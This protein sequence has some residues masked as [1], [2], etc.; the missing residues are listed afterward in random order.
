[1]RDNDQLPG[2]PVKPP[3]TL[4]ARLLSPLG[5]DGFLDEPDGLLVVD[6]DGRIAW[7][8]GASDR[9]GGVPPNAMDVRPMVVLPGLVDLHGHLP[10]L[11]ISGVGSNLGILD[12]LGDLMGPVERRFGRA[13]SARLSPR[14]FRQ[15]AAAGTTTACLYTSVDA[16]AT[17]AAFEAAERHGIRV[18][19]GQPLMDVGRYDADVP[20]RDVTDIRLSEAAQTCAKWNGRDGGRIMYTF[21]PRGALN[22]TARMMAESA[23]MARDAGAYWQTHLS[24]DLDEVKAVLGVHPDARDVLDTYER[25]GGL[26]PRCILAHCVYINERELARIAETGTVV[27]HCP[28]NVWLN[29]GVMRLAYYRERGLKVGLGADVGANMGGVSLWLAMQLGLISQSA[30]AILLGDREH[31]RRGRLRMLDWLRLATLDGARCLGIDDRIGSL[32]ISKDAD[33]ILVDPQMTSPVPGE[34]LADFDE[35]EAE[36]LMSRLISRP[37]PEMVRAAWVRGR[38]LPGPGGWEFDE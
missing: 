6:G 34:R 18:N 4:R 8:G 30:R 23:V 11:P 16:G 5:S 12:W 27:A 21:T 17:D 14:Y 19:M 26:G 20:D 35:D 1:M 25:A 3:F 2:F 29:F 10:Q 22:C 32:E 36:H 28:S 13:E 9:P 38:R 15:F 33:L 24:E 31:D 37:H 7:A